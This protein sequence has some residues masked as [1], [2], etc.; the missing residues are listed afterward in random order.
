MTT[1]PQADNPPRVANLYS[2]TASQLLKSCETQKA[3]AAFA[4]AFCEAH[5]VGFRSPN[6]NAYVERF[7]QSIQQEC[8]DKFIVFGGSWW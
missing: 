4:K 8:L 2:G 6:L 5:R 1:D 7:V 3:L